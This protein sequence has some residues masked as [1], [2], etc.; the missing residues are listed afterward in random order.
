MQAASVGFDDQ[1]FYEFVKNP[2]GNGLKLLEHL[3]VENSM[4]PFGQWAIKDDKRM[5]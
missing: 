5:Y 2:N 4:E 3:P 1:N